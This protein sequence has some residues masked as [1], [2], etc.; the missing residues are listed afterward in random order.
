MNS[1]GATDPRP[2]GDLLAQS[3]S[4]LLDALEALAEHREAVVVIGA[5]AIYIRT[6]DAPVALAEAT[7]DSDLAMDPRI[8]G[9]NPAVDDAMTAAGFRLNPDSGQPG[10]WVT[11]LGIPVDLMVPEALAGPGGAST[12]GARLPP[13]DKRSM[14]RARGLEAVVV[15][16]ST[17]MVRSLDPEDVR[18]YPV[19]V[20]GPAAL[21]VAK[22]HKIAERLDQPKRLQDKDAHD[23]YR[24]FRAIE[25]AELAA[26]FRRLLSSSVSY[27]AAEEA[28]G[29]VATLLASGPDAEA[30]V[31]AGRAEEGIGEPETVSLAISILAQDL[32]DALSLA[33]KDQAQDLS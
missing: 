4:A 13:H 9:V 17:E 6:P 20:A 24:V 23:I 8:L 30:S 19:K 16:N 33:D 27:S 32:L 14:R 2:G 25:T 28:L 29:H 12:R 5:Q 10:A 18:A 11:P 21:V 1:P 22:I 31:M 3:R 7:K 26:G 15:D